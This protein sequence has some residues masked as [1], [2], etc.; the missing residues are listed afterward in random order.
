MEVKYILFYSDFR[1][2][3][4]GP[5]LP[6]WQHRHVPRAAGF[7]GRQIVT[8]EAAMKLFWNKIWLMTF[9]FRSPIIEMLGRRRQFLKVPRGAKFL[10]PGLHVKP[11]TFLKYRNCVNLQLL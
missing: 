10:N 4:S 8:D 6:N 11:E 7:R 1:T 9:F 3:C 2:P 5:Y